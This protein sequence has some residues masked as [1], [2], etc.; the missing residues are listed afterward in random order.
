MLLK[1]LL[2]VGFSAERAHQVMDQD[3]KGWEVTLLPNAERELTMTFQV[4]KPNCTA[5]MLTAPFETLYRQ[6][7]ELWKAEFGQH[8]PNNRPKKYTRQ[9][10]KALAAVQDKI[11]SEGLNDTQ[12]EQVRKMVAESFQAVLHEQTELKQA[13]E[14]VRAT[15]NEL[16]QVTAAQSNVIQQAMP[17]LTQ[18]KFA[19]AFQ[20]QNSLPAPQYAA[21][22]PA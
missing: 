5:P 12:L 15:T 10:Q 2:A 17:A 22:A 20:P 4:F 1:E 21:A 7:A 9:Q 16:L 3:S 6:V 18:F 11:H 14:S 8:K 13:V 19:M